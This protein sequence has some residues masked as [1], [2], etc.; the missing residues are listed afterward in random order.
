[1][2]CQWL[3]VPI[4]RLFWGRPAR[5]PCSRKSWTSCTGSSRTWWPC[6][7]S[8]RPLAHSAWMIDLP[9][10]R[11]SS[12]HNPGTSTCPTS[13]PACSLVARGPASG[14]WVRKS[15]WGTGRSVLGWSWGIDYNSGPPAKYYFNS[16]IKIWR[17]PKTSPKKSPNNNSTRKSTTSWTNCGRVWTTNARN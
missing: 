1:M 6:T 12:A 9:C 14:L 15:R 5:K 11:A 8:R 3:L 16:N 17:P 10:S 2:R 7:P 13:T 4:F